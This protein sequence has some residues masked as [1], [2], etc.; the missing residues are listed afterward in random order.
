MIA[1]DAEVLNRAADLIERDGWCQG[2]DR[3]KD[4]ICVGKAIELSAEAL[5]A[6]WGEDFDARPAFVAL[7]LAAGIRVD[8]DHRSFGGYVLWNDAPGRTKAEVV[9]VLRSAAERAA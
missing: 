5:R 2:S 7:E 1:A 6:L 8:A 3:L 4:G 9:A